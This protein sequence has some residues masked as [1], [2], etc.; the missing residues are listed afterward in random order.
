MQ[1]ITLESIDLKGRTASASTWS[2]ATAIVIMTGQNRYA[3][4]RH[5]RSTF[6]RPLMIRA[7]HA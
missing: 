5:L 1:E 6:H 4:Q 7:S 2:A 3:L